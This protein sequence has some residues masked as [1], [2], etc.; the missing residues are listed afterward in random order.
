MIETPHC[1]YAT[2][3]LHSYQPTLFQLFTA[4]NNI[5]YIEENENHM[6]LYF[7]H[8]MHFDI[9]RS[10]EEDLTQAAVAVIGENYNNNFRIKAEL[11]E[12]QAENP[13]Q[14]LTIVKDIFQGKEV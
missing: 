1:I 7:D 13:N 14:N 9:V 2:L 12:K 4:L 10:Y 11:V 6:V 8:K 3:I 5:K